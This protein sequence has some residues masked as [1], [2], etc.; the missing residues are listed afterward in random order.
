MTKSDRDHLSAVARLGCTVCRNQF[1]VFSEAEIH[2]IRDGQGWRKGR[3]LWI[4]DQAAFIAGLETRAE[5]IYWLRI[6]TEQNPEYAQTVES[7][8]FE[9]YQALSVDHGRK[10][11]RGANAA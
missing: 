2:H 7:R 8:V 10:N 3:R 6:V 9:I 1:G 5:R 11:K 4:D